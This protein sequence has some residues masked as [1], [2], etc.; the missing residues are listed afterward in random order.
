MDLC[1]HL[2]RR[3]RPRGPAAPR[4]LQAELNAIL[5][6]YVGRETPLYYAERLS[7]HYRRCGAQR[8]AGG[9]GCP[10]AAAAR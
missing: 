6:D 4:P 7:R 2:A 9:A 8:A 5:K 10:G 1:A 3:R